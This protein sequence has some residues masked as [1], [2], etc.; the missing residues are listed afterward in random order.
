M[1]ILNKKFGIIINLL[2]IE[3]SK[4]RNR[5]NFLLA[6]A[7]NCNTYHIATF[8]SSNLLTITS[9]WKLGNRK[10]CISHTGLFYKKN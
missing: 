10:A 8:H 3:Q 5:A 9:R 7:T 6:M 2:L 1:I 4:N